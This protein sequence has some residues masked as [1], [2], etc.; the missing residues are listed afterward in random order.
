VGGSPE[1]LAPL[2]LLALVGANETAVWF[3]KRPKPLSGR[4][5]ATS[6]AG[7]ASLDDGWRIFPY[8]S[9]QPMEESPVFT[10]FDF[11]DT[12]GFEV[13]SD[14]H[15]STPATAEP[16][17]AFPGRQTVECYDKE[18]TW[19][20]RLK[21]PKSMEAGERNLKCQMNYQLMNDRVVTFPGRWTLQEVRVKVSR[22]GDP[23]P[24][25]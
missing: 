1:S 4:F 16:V 18:V 17:R 19:S 2:A 12:G 20:I 13:V 14:W 23:L 6:D 10:K 11:F 7:N 22:S 9:E 8:S 5:N 24:V 21:V 15:A 3:T 25:A